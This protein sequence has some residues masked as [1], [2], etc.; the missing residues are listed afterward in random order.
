MTS[1]TRRLLEAVLNAIS[2]CQSGKRTVGTLAALASA[3]ADAVDEPGYTD[4]CNDLCDIANI[5][6]EIEYCGSKPND[7]HVIEALHHVERRLRDVLGV[8]S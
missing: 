2:E 7:W 6:E 3:N 4:L 8:P 1:H 5:A